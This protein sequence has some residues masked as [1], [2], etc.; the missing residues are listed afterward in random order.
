MILSQ[1]EVF[2]SLKTKFAQLET[3][4]VEEKVLLAALSPQTEARYNIQRTTLELSGSR[5]TV[6]TTSS[7]EQEPVSLL[8][9]A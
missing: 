2:S 8:A 4:V 1:S 9:E 7:Q 6:K 5:S 3:E